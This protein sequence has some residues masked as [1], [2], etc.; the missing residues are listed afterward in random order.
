VEIVAVDRQGE[1]AEVRFLLLSDQPAQQLAAATPP[2]DA[3]PP[4]IDFGG[5]H[6][7][8]IGNDDYGKLPDLE[9]AVADASAVSEILE[10]RYGFQVTSLHNATR[11][12]ILSEL[13]R[14]TGNLTKEDN[15]LVYYA[16]HGELD[17][18]NQVGHWLPVDAEPE[19]SANWLST[20]SLTDQL[21]RMKA[22]HVLVVADSCY[23][24]ALTRAGVTQLRSGETA[25]ER[26]G[27][28]RAQLGLR[29]RMALT[30]GGLKPVLDTGAGKHSVF[31]K[32][33][34][35]VLQANSGVLDGMSLYQAIAAKVVEAARENDFDQV[36]EYAP[37][38]HGHHENGHFLFV[39]RA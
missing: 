23:S 9:S 25:D 34:I 11:Y 22:R 38:R 16:G 31:A 14:L 37:I 6:A 27:W 30:S 29:V 13:N 15:L 19:N 32:F 1:R 12:Q 20:R 2:V 36:P 26:L 17:R 28:I 35:E 10:S 4:G 33:F 21:N 3:P 5:Y 18:V 39:P 8:V 24:G 7:L